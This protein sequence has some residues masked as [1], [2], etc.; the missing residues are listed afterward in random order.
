MLIIGESINSTIPAVETAINGRDESFIAELARDQVAAGAEMLDVNVAVAEGNEVENLLWAVDVVQ[1]AADV[2][3]ALDSSNPDA[4][5]A[6]LQ[7]HRGRPILNSISGEERKL[8]TLLPLAAKHDCRVILLCL[9]DRGIPKTPEE[10][11][12]VAVSLVEKATREGIAAEDLYVDPLVLTIGSDWRAARLAL[13]T[14]RLIR[15]ALPEVH[16]SG[17]VTNV[18][19]GMP[20]RSLL[21]RTLLA[22][23][24]AQGMDTFLVNVRDRGVVATIYAANTLLGNDAYCSDYLDAYHAGKLDVR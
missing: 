6:A 16:I 11:C 5:E 4:L 18:S 13:D 8:N 24:I 2:P 14:V 9:D 1:R 21:N 22:M 10:R 19:F 15:K 23:A 3:L 7:I 20:Q 12:A 17:G